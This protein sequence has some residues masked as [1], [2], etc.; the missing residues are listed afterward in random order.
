MKKQSFVLDFEIPSSLVNLADLLTYYGHSD[1]STVYHL[2]KV[3]H[4]IDFLYNRWW[5]SAGLNRHDYVPTNC[6]IM[7]E[8]YGDHYYFQI[9]E[10]LL[11]IGIIESTNH[12]Y[13]NG[14]FW[15]NAGYGKE[16]RISKVF[17]ND[18]AIEITANHDRFIKH[19][20]AYREN[21]EKSME[22]K[23]KRT[24]RKLKQTIIHDL[25]IDVEGAIEYCLNKYPFTKY[26]E[27]I[28]IDDAI[29]MAESLTGTEKEITVTKADLKKYKTRSKRKVNKAGGNWINAKWIESEI[30][31]HE[32]LLYDLKVIKHIEKLQDGDTSSLIFTNDNEAKRLFT[33][34]SQISRGVRHF[35]RL[36]GQPLCGPDVRNSQPLMLALLI[37]KIRGGRK[38]L[39]KD[40]ELYLQHCLEGTFYN[41]MM[42]KFNVPQSRRAEFKATFFGKTL[43]CKN[44]HMDKDF[45]EY[46]QEHY[47]S[48]YR[49]IRNRKWNNYKS[50]AIELQRIERWFIIDVVTTS[51]LRKNSFIRI[52]TLHDCLYT[53]KEHVEFVREELLYQ[54]KKKFKVLPSVELEDYQQNEES[55]NSSLPQIILINRNHIKVL[56]YPGGKLLAVTYEEGEILTADVT[57]LIDQFKSLT[58]L[59]LDQ[60]L[61]IKQRQE[62]II[63]IQEIPDSREAA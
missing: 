12:H 63:S 51:V 20:L 48:V 5:R 1:L 36:K 19:V 26:K 50:L 49:T 56:R 31:S 60:L 16:Y 47:P 7:G 27:E 61:L 33:S 46:M 45:S 38:N 34:F 44:L 29:Y 22:V 15:N 39:A 3:Y 24:Y 42:E 21:E 10:A 37:I 62:S 40:E 14:W 59:D 43:F 18:P 32:A 25:S 4:F 9:K 53:T 2:D 8:I 6:L 55:V 23:N 11:Q 57:F 30:Y 54:F 35:L 41:R 13:N 52:I 58:N 17:R 28:S